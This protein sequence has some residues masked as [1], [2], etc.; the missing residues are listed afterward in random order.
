MSAL[1]IHL[2]CCYRAWLHVSSDFTS[3]AS[4]ISFPVVG[5]NISL[6][7]FHFRLLCRIKYS[8][9]C[10][11]ASPFFRGA[12]R[13]PR[14]RRDQHFSESAMLAMVESRWGATPL[15]YMKISTKHTAAH[16]WAPV[17]HRRVLDRISELVEEGLRPV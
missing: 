17:L 3:R 11:S 9:P 1:A 13:A 2:Y 4:I 12:A 6:V 8:V 10:P 16:A 14:A 5:P 15:K 7:F